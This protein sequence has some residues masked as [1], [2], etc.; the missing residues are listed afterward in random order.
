[1]LYIASDH[2]GFNLKKYLLE[3]LKEKLHKEVVDLGSD[4]YNETDDYPDYAFKLAKEVINDKNN[5]GILICG[6]GHGMC[7]AANK[8][9]GIR[10]ALGYS[11][12]GAES[13]RKEDDANVM[14]LAGR[15]LSNDYAGAIVK[16]F[17]ETKFNGLDRM[18]RR[19]EKISQLEK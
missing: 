17:L 3:Y 10:A 2:A 13:A 4:K 11:T 15:V 12:S 6:S 9:E 8:V 19:I 5:I 7:I 14:C 1:M 18:N 16:K